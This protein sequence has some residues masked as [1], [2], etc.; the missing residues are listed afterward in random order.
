MMSSTLGWQFE[1]EA[2]TPRESVKL[3][4]HIHSRAKRKVKVY[5]LYARKL[6]LNAGFVTVSN[7]LDAGLRVL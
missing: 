4:L 2:L 1:F 3:E 5:L 6:D 7:S